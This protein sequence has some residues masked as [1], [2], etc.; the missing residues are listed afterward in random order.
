MAVAT[1]QWDSVTAYAGSAPVPTEMFR[2]NNAN[3][4]DRA[5]IVPHTTLST[6]NGIVYKTPRLPA[7]AITG[8]R[9][10][11]VLRHSAASGSMRKNAHGIWWR[12]DDGD[13]WTLLE[14]EQEGLPTSGSP[15]EGFHTISPTTPANVQVLVG[16]WEQGDG[17]PIPTLD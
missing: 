1:V 9:V 5:T 2:S 17:D 6:V 16:N 7:G 12:E 10:R 8:L 13:P 4:T 11:A 15:E 14:A 3:D